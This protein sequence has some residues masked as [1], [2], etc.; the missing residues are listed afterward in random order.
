[1]TIAAHPAFDGLDIILDAEQHAG[2]GWIAHYGCISSSM[3]FR[4]HRRALHRSAAQAGA[5]RSR[6]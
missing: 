6:A 5:C 1:M 4:D 3:L 2:Q